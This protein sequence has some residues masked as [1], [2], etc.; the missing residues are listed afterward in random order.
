MEFL[1]GPLDD[2]QLVVHRSYYVN[3]DVMRGFRIDNGYARGECWVGDD[4]LGSQ[5][6]IWGLLGIIYMVQIGWKIANEMFWVF[7]KHGLVAII[8]MDYG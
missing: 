8:L 2:G 3:L 4:L 1:E 5:V 6:C 7:I